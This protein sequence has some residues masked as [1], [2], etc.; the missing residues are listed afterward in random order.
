M[1]TSAKIV[2]WH[3]DYGGTGFVDE[4]GCYS[5]IAPHGETV[6][7]IRPSVTGL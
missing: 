2:E 5:Y 3:V 6:V 4:P 7:F 1:L